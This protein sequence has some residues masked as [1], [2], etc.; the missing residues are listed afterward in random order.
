MPQQ[1][2]ITSEELAK[3]GKDKSIIPI[4]GSCRGPPCV[5]DPKIGC[6][7]ARW[8]GDMLAMPDELEIDHVVY[9]FRRSGS[10]MSEKLSASD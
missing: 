6:L 4:Y 3:L 7:K 1:I 10:E 5:Y 9:K 8:V 2:E